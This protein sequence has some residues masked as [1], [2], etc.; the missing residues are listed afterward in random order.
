MNSNRKSRNLVT[1]LFFLV[2][3]TE[4]HCCLQILLVVSST[5]HTVGKQARGALEHKQ[6]EPLKN[7]YS[8]GFRL[9]L[10]KSLPISHDSSISCLVMWS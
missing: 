8:F 6:Q 3:G 5:F 1:D 9:M 7:L 2:V 10:V 4:I